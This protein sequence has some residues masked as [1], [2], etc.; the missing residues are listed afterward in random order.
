MAGTVGVGRRDTAPKPASTLK[1][2][3]WLVLAVS[4]LATVSYG[5]GD[6]ILHRLAELEDTPTA[7]ALG[8]IVLFGL[9]SF[10]SFYA[11]W[12]TPIPSFVVAI[13]L[14]IAGHKLLVPI[15]SSP[16]LPASLVTG[17]AAI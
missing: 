16:T 4:T 7:P 12:Q 14:G 11:T 8:A 17:S 9:C 2:Y 1:P 5:A 13:A 6:Q 3:I 15:I 10:A